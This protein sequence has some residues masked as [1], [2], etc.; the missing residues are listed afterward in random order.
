M[1]HSVLV[2]KCNAALDMHLDGAEA[3]VRRFRKEEAE[4][5][6]CWKAWAKDV[7]K[8]KLQ[9]FCEHPKFTSDRNF[10]TCAECGAS[11]NR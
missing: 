1:T 4:A 9:M 10:H 2:E 3:N 8:T 11:F 5:R 7:E 6:E